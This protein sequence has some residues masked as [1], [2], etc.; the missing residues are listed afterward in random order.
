MFESN[1]KKLL[2]YAYD[3]D[4]Q[5]EPQTN[6]YMMGVFIAV[7]FARNLGLTKDDI[8]GEMLR[9]WKEIDNQLNEDTMG[10]AIDE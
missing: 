6:I 5:G 4:N 2:W 9:Q 10:P 1:I 8:Y 3:L 7:V